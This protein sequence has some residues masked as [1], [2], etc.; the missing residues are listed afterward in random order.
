MQNKK[1]LI[2]GEVY[3]DHHLDIK[4][5]G[6][7]VSRLGG[8]FH[9]ARACD[10]LN[11]CFSLAYFAPTYLEKDIKKYGVNILGAQKLYC[12]GIIDKAPNIMLI[13]NSDENGKQLYEN[14]LAGQTEYVS[15][16][17]L[18]KVVDDCLP[19][20][21]VMFPGRYKNETLLNELFDFKGK[22]HIDMNYDCNGLLDHNKSKIETVFISTS[23]TSF[24]ELF[25]RNSYDELIEY[26]RNYNVNEILVKENKGGS[27][28]YNYDEKQE[29]ESPAFLNYNTIHSVG[30]GDVYNIAYIC[31]SNLI[32]INQSM[33]FASWIS[34]FYS[35]TFSH[36][37]FKDNVDLIY[38]NIDEFVGM[39]GIRVPWNKRKDYPIYMAAP[40]FDYVN[41]RKFDDLVNALNYHNFFPRCP[42]KENGQ[43]NEKMNIN[44]KNNIYSKDIG[45]LSECKLMIATLLYNDQGTLVEI[46][47]YHA[48][49]KTIILY[50]P[51]NIVNN[52]F[53][54]NSCTYYC[55]NLS[56][57]I[58]AVFETVSRM[59]KDEKGL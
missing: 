7:S 18:K 38:N 2:I 46:G 41:T 43:V 24:A 48:N 30:V 47:N 9:A 26:F 32:A 3:V 36:N 35:T 16:K 33:A 23:S 40:D 8:V 4:E 19:S 34:S 14:V 52:M 42:I 59:L 55:K 6:I 25:A 1:V 53:L 44:D 56:E 12:L 13:D 11:I 31:V 17:S 50:D 39:E 22:I 57:V 54:E 27:W 15:M 45:L 51:Y 49:G 37:K 29:Y 20:D 10:A 58:K 21:I 28:L 5:N